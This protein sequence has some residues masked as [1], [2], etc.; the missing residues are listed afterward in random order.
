MA[1][2]EPERYTL[3]DDGLIV[4][5][6]G[7]WTV[8]NLKSLS[9]YVYASGGAR[10]HFERADSGYID[11]F[12]GPGRSLIRHTTKFIDGSAVAAFKRSLE[13]ARRFT[14][15]NVSDTDD[16]LLA[17]EIEGG[18]CSCSSNCRSRK[19]SDIPDRS[20]LGP[21]RIA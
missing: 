14:S 7:S 21:I 13:S 16:E 1:Q 4:E 11:I 17:A 19:P 15:V 2:R 12:C 3:G 20:E 10:S 8:E 9:D 5:K 18:R 6:V